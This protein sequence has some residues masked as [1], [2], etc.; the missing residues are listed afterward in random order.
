MKVAKNK[1]S[2][3]VNLFEVISTLS[4]GELEKFSSFLKEK[5]RVTNYNKFL[6]LILDLIKNNETIETID[7]GLIK[8][9]VEINE[10]SSNFSKITQNLYSRLLSYL[11]DLYKQDEWKKWQIEAN[12]RLNEVE[13]LCNRKLY[14]Q[15]IS[16]LLKIEDKLKKKGD[17]KKWIYD[18]I[19]IYSKLANL[20]INLHFWAKDIIH[21]D[22]FDELLKNLLKLGDYFYNNKL[23]IPDDTLFSNHKYIGY[24]ILSEYFNKKKDYNSSII[25][26]KKAIKNIKTTE[27][28]PEIAGFMHQYFNLIKVFLD[29][30]LNN[31]IPYI[32]ERKQQSTPEI[33]TVMLQEELINS[34][35]TSSNPFEQL[36]NEEN[37]GEYLTKKLYYSEIKIECLPDRLE[38]NRAIHFCLRKKFHESQEIITEL[39]SKKRNKQKTNPIFLDLLFLDLLCQIGNKEFDL[40][41]IFR[42]LKSCIKELNNPEFEAIAIKLLKKYS[43]L[44]SFGRND[45][46]TTQEDGINDLTKS[47]DITNPIHSLI[48]MTLRNEV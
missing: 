29:A 34:I 6:D 5:R 39:K 38:L 15:A 16:L 27:R 13:A 43:N 24:Q 37:Q 25:S 8:Q 17:Y 40:D 48:L 31:N 12:N 45:F 36:L 7:E 22:E 32:N 4:T 19:G 2:A 35:K 44:N 14:S 42:S 23:R 21:I 9:Q 18:D 11:S 26:I 28:N 3:F 10:I 47:K 46:L 33:M 30:K 1:K 20:K 41:S